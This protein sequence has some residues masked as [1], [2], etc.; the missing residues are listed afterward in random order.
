MSERIIS[1]KRPDPDFMTFLEAMNTQPVVFKGKY[2]KIGYIHLI[3]GN[4]YTFN[5]EA[6]K[7]VRLPCNDIY[8]PF[9]G[10]MISV[11]VLAFTTV[12]GVPHFITNPLK[13]HIF[14]H[15]IRYHVESNDIGLYDQANC[16]APFSY[17]PE[18]KRLDLAHQAR[19]MLVQGSNHQMIH[20][21]SLTEFTTPYVNPA[22]EL[23]TQEYTKVYFTHLSEEYSSKF[24]KIP[25]TKDILS[26]FVVQGLFENNKLFQAKFQSALCAVLMTY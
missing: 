11:L 21:E 14:D 12:N 10:A 26:N 5:H 18:Q 20:L 17:Q 25:V 8:S 16:G 15:E 3:N 2:P 23:I 13:R 24:Q 6:E 7:Q 22:I 4:Y 19:D 1:L 9:H